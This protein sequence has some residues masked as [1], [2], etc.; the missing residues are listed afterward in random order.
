MYQYF[1]LIKDH[2]A[3][4][5]VWPL[6]APV[7][8]KEIWWGKNARRALTPCLLGSCP[9]ACHH[10]LASS[11]GQTHPGRVRGS[12]PLP[13]LG[14]LQGP[15]ILQTQSLSNLLRSGG[16]VCNYLYEGKEVSLNPRSFQIIFQDLTTLTILAG[17][18]V[19]GLAV[20]SSAAA[21]LPILASR[22]LS[23]R[24]RRWSI[25]GR[26]SLLLL[27]RSLL[28]SSLLAVGALLSISS[29]LP[30]IASLLLLLLGISALLGLLGIGVLLVSR[31]LLAAR[32]VTAA[33]KHCI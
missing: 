25:A 24:P 26:R 33:N 7:W 27:R 22:G 23:I 28:I 29:L 21:L 16:P 5:S 11:P 12:P 1:I 18:F 14:P 4:S 8:R 17:W 32:T 2:T 9:L 30:L 31:R 15:H 3:L 10:L 20:S 19:I 6:S 13:C